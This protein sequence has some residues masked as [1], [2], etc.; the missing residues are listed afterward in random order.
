MP[1]KLLF[2]K[3]KKVSTPHSNL[4]FFS[5]GFEQMVLF[6]INIVNKYISYKEY[7]IISVNKITFIVLNNQLYK[8][9]TVTGCKNNNIFVKI[10]NI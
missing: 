9:T 5:A 4:P 10:D 3:L 8:I 1:S 2:G 6:L 7:N